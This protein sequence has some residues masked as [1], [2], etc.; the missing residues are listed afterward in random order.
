MKISLL[1]KKDFSLLMSAKLVSLVGTNLQ[2]FALSLYVLKIT[3]SATKFASVLALA[4]IPQLVI[5]PF[6]GVFV[7]WLDRKKIIVWLDVLSGIATGIFA[8]VFLVNGRLSMASVYTLVIVLSLISTLYQPAIGTVIPSITEKDDLMDA[9]GISSIIMNIGNLLSPVLGGLIYGIFGLSAVLVLNA[10]SFLISSAAELFICIPK[11]EKA[12]EEMNIKTFKTDFMEG[13][14]FIK[15]R[16]LILTIVFMAA[17]INFA[18][19]PMS[20]GLTYISVNILKITYFQLGIVEFFSVIAMMVA[21]ILASYVSKKVILGKILFYSL[22]SCS[23]VV[24]VMA[25]VPAHAY[26]GLFKTNLIPYISLII[27]CFF[28][29]IFVTIANIA[30]GVMFQKKVPLELMGRVGT[31]MSAGCLACAPLGQMIFGILYD[32][33]NPSVCF[34]IEG[35]IALAAVLIFRKGLFSESDEE[36]GYSDK[37]IAE[38]IS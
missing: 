24:I 21:P 16:R 18:F 15:T 32:N 35:V 19:S 30:L 13:I 26:L 10:V 12:P 33:I 14:N 34:I 6:A 11:N 23:A 3:G 2:D 36:Q 20:V 17:I 37:E 1:K 9:N 38:T 8:A 28:T 7:D 5:G 22:M 29:G 27:L 31:V 25:V 4:V